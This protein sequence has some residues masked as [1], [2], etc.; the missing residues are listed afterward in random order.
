MIPLLRNV[1]KKQIQRQENRLVT[2]RDQGGEDW[3]LALNGN[4]IYSG[5]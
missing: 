2:A 5:G 1:Q 3:G 4:R